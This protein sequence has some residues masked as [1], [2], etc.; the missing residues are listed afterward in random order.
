MRDPAFVWSAVS[1]L[2]ALASWLL[3]LFWRRLLGFVERLTDPPIMRQRINEGSDKYFVWRHQH[4]SDSEVD[5]V[6]GSDTSDDD[7]D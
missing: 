5:D 3:R 7:Y 4:E 6:L 1:S 2:L